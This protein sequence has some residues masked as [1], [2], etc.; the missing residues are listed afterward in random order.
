LDTSKRELFAAMTI[1]VVYNDR[2]PLRL[3]PNA[4]G[5]AKGVDAPLMT[6]P[7]IS[8]RFAVSSEGDEV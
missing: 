4:L 2:P 8:S 3:L 7:L 6:L 5:S 1:F